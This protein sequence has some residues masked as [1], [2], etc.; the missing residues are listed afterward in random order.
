MLFVPALIREKNWIYK[1]NIF[2]IEHPLKKYLWYQASV[3]MPKIIQRLCCSWITV[4]WSRETVWFSP[5][6][7]LLGSMSPGCFFL[8]SDMKPS[9]SAPPCFF[10]STFHWP[11]SL[12]LFQVKYWTRTCATTS[13]CSFRR[14]PWT[15]SSSRWSGTTCTFAPSPVSIAS[16]ASGSFFF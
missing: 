13:A 10:H 3:K 1:L 7:P 9:E 15:T 5:S 14:A 12:F 2:T 6:I 4:R 16:A 11:L 8:F